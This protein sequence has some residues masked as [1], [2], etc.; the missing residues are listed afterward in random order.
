[1]SKPKKKKVSELK[2]NRC[3]HKITNINNV[4]STPKLDRKGS[5]LKPLE[6]ILSK[7]PKDGCL[8]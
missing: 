3:L 5:T 6:M 8:F 2:E 7:I 1:M 4:V